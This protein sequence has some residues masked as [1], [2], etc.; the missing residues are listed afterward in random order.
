[1]DAI[2]EAER[3]VHRYQVSAGSVT[4]IVACRARLWIAQGELGA[5]ARWARESGLL[6]D[7]ELAY[8]REPEQIIL[9]WLPIAQGE[10]VQAVGLLE[11]LL[12][13]AEA[14]G[15]QGSAIEILTLLAL[16]WQ[17][18]N[19]PAPALDA[20]ARALILAEPAGYVRTFVD[21]GWPMATLVRRATSPGVVPAYCPILATVVL[22]LQ[23]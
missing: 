6:A 7:S 15:R 1:L 21:K 5:A 20:L 9:A 16:A 12:E 10:P 4:R 18:Q 11:R 23:S 8:P 14:Q 22:L 13:V 17:A 19:K 3:L 2:G